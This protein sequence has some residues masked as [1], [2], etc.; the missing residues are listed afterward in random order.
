MDDFL[1]AITLALPYE[2]RLM[3]YSYTFSVDFRPMQK[4]AFDRNFTRMHSL[5]PRDVFFKND[6]YMK[7][8]RSHVIDPRS[9]QW[10][11][12]VEIAFFKGNP[13]CHR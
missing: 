7:L 8:R 5:P 10:L 4:L 13:R 11:E 3:V 6:A 12:N 9:T 1:E 2:L